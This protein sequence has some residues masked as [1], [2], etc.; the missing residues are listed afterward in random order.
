MKNLPKIDFLTADPQEILAEC[1]AIVEESLGRKLGRADPI[2]ILLEA[3]VAILISLRLLI[4]EVAKQNLLAYAKGDN[5]DHLGALVGVERLPAVH[6]VTTVE[7]TLSAARLQAT[8]I[9]QGTRITADGK[10][11]FALDEDVVFSAGEIS[12]TCAATCLSTGEVGN[13]FA[14]GEINKIVDPQAWLLSIVNITKSEGGADVESDDALRERIHEAPESFSVAGPEGAY[15]FWAK[16]ASQL[17]AD[18]EVRTPAPTEV[19]VFVLLKNGVLPETEM[20][21]L[22]YETLSDK[23]RRPLTDKVSVL[24]PTVVNFD[25]DI[26]Y[27]IS[28]DDAVNAAQICEDA[29][30]AVADYVAWQKEKIGR[31]INPDELI[32]RLKNI[33]VKRAEIRSPQFSVVNKFEVAIAQN[34]QNSFGGLE[35]N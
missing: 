22:V 1:V 23:T 27:F 32:K 24:A 10:I 2:R 28:R 13:N 30:A 17:I 6:A 18:V 9:L 14:Q 16:S 15:K 7:V 5:L 3:F 8:T 21:D 34:V 29:E 11:F 12:K 35:D 26:T 25:L 4:D 31:D 19:E 20:L 33:G